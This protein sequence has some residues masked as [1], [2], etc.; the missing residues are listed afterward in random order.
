[1]LIDGSWVDEPSRVKEEVHRIFQQR[2]QAVLLNGGHGGAMADLGGGFAKK[3]H[4]IAVAWRVWDGGAM[5]A[6][7]AIAVVAVMA[8]WR[9][10]AF[11]F[12]FL[13]AVGVGLT[14]PNPTRLFIQLKDPPAQ[15]CDSEQPSI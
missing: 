1:M 6:A 13:S 4:R 11:F 3:R 15:L 8:G 5:A 12:C 2:F 9:K 14:R 7:L 10:M